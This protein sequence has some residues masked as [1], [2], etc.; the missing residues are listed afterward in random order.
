MY[1]PFGGWYHATKHALEGWSDAL[2]LETRPFGIDVVIVEPGG[3][4]TDWGTIA[5]ENLR[6]TSGGGAY[7]EA[8]IRTADGLAKRYESKQLSEP[9]L[10]AK[11]ILTAVTARRPKTRYAAGSYARLSLFLRWLLSD[12]AFDKL[13]QSMA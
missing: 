6:K 1:T 9:S 12:R 3:I 4:T 10:I 13:I 11:V 8:A 7:S 5:A 2:R